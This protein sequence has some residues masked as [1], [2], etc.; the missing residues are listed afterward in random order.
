MSLWSRIGN[1]LRPASLHR[2]L[3]EE[4]ESHIEEAISSGRDPI[5]ARRALGS[6]LCHREA[7]RD[8]KLLNWVDSLRADAV[9]G[10]RQLN[11][12]KITSAAAILSLALA[13]G[14][15]T[16]AFRL[17]DALLL[18]PLPV[19]GTDRLYAL[20]RVG[21]N[22]EG[23]P[24]KFDSN[25]FL[26]FK[27]MRTAVKDQAELFAISSV[28]P[29]DLTY[30]SDQE[31]EKAH[32]QYVSGWMFSAFL[33]RP[34]LGRTLAE[35][36]DLEPGARPYAVLSYDYWTRRF[37][38]DPNIVGHAFRMGN[39]LYQIVGVATPGFTGTEPGTFADVF[40]PT[41]MNEGVTHSDWAWVRVLVQL[42]PGA[43][44]EPVRAR[45]HA[46]YRAFQEERTKDF[47]GAQR[48]RI[49]N[50]I[51]QRVVLE[52]AASGM[53]SMQIGNLPSLKI[54]SVLVGLVLLVAIVNVANL[55]TARA[56][57]RTREMAVRISIGGG[58]SRL[59]QMVLI[60]SA[61]LAILAAAIG[62]LFSFWAAPFVVSHINPPSNPA[63]LA[64]PADW[65]VFGFGLLMTVA[66]TFLFGLIPALRASAINPISALKGADDPQA[67][68]HLMHAL[69]AAQIAFSILILFVAALFVATFQRLA[70]QPT[71]FSAERLLTLDT[72]S[73]GPQPPAFWNQ[74]TED[75][76]A[77]PRIESVAVA[78]WPLLRGD[79]QNRFVSIDGKP[80]T[81]ILAYFLQVSPGWF[82]TMK[83]PLLA[84][85][86]F[87]TG[88]TSPSVAIVNEA[89]ARAYFDGENPI[90]RWF[91]RTAQPRLRFQ[92][93]GL[94]ANASYRS[95]RE[96]I[97]P[98]AYL[99]FQ[100]LDANSLSQPVERGTFL[101]RTSDT[102]P[103]SM[104]PLLRLEVPRSRPEFR[105][106]NIRTQ[107][108]INASQMIRERLLAMLALFFAVVALLLAGV[109]L[110]GV[111]HY[112]VQR[113][114]REFGIRMAIGAQAS[115]IARLVITEPFAM[116]LL[117][118]LT[119]VALG[120]TSTRY[121]ATLL[122]LVKP[123]DALI[124]TA[125]IAGL[126]AVAVLAALPPT[127]RAIET[128]PSI[129]LRTE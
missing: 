44:L 35:A 106:S 75:L 99:P 121:I 39:N 40:I 60:E 21:L 59:V 54:L 3:D 33:L 61:W 86:D 45:L 84:G 68:L 81:Q 112:A 24:G 57:G 64:L 51:N 11:K 2:E 77:I 48:A 37:G 1:A 20:F 117:G 13:I 107:T 104:A 26:L 88:D 69:I 55:M 32:V 67:R 58:R 87:R 115:A 120:L 34:A 95:M 7:S 111:F 113:R 103:L 73:Q 124:L 78:E 6:L 65:R 52:R 93:V 129:V 114:Q 100:S 101:V 92:I 62:A 5:E 25:E 18:R 63:R 122:Y 119:G 126:V 71:G 19:A 108:E 70:H 96:P 56:S 76:R 123:T 98:V 109:G 17:I 53:S 46:T 27:L 23:K 12:S 43:T 16:S 14:A 66:V 41:M 30:K 29:K 127:L 36:D 125:P 50:F 91:Q 49:D 118:A 90:G 82:G 31:I 8:A 128:D 42:R 22:F 38:N 74:V 79:S 80:S 116:F 110:Y 102:D 83:I 97:L 15:C 105:V 9:F 94:A 89:F 85:R 72:V 47:V 4:L 28:A 10:W